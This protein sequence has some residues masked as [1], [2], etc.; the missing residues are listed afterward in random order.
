MELSKCPITHYTPIVIAE[1]LLQD[2]QFNDNDITLE[3][4]KG[5]GNSFYDLIPYEKDWCE[6]D[7]DRDLFAW[8]FGDKLF[9]KVITNP[10]YLS[11][12]TNKE[13][14]K[15]IA[16]KVIEKCFD[17]STDECW[18]LLNNQMFNSITPARL[19]KY[20]KKGFSLVF[21]RILNIPCWYGRYYWICFKKNSK[22]I[23][24]F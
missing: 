8:D 20:Y 14:R 3:P 22:S 19:R 9:T 7:Q 5:L 16:I 13:D 21:M 10:P 18:F 6:I 24:S 23:V 17:L 4:C 11:N 2:I 15:N 1:Q 12:E